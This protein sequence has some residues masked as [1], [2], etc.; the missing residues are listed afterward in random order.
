LNIYQKSLAKHLIPVDFEEN[1]IKLTGFVSAIEMTR[2]NRQYQIAFVNNRY[3]KSKTVEEAIATVY[4]TLIP[5][6]RFPIVFLNVTIDPSLIDI[7]IH[8]AKTEIRFHQEGLIK[9][10]IYKAVKFEI[11]KYNLVPSKPLNSKQLPNKEVLKSYYD[12]NQ[13]KDEVKEKKQD[14]IMPTQVIKEKVAEATDKKAFNFRQTYPDRPSKQETNNLLNSYKSLIQDKEPEVIK[15][16]V[17]KPMLRTPLTKVAEVVEEIYEAPKQLFED[18]QETIYDHLNFIGQMFQTYLIYEKNS[19]MYLIDQH[20]AHEKILYEKF[21]DDYKNKKM[22]SQM[23]LEPIVVNV[24]KMTLDN[25]IENSKLFLN[26]GFSIEAFGDDALLIREIP[27]GF[28]I[29]TSKLIFENLIEELDFKL[30]KERF[31]LALD[32]LASRSCKAAIKA[33][34]RLMDIEVS[35]LVNQLKGL[36]EPYTCPHGRPIIIKISKSEIEKKFNRT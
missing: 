32:E 6:N 29:K 17:S 23:I 13:T 35:G 7:N 11:N 1:G 8:P 21:L 3:V 22:M 9:D 15:E 28:N 20:A 16:S 30:P 31:E 24:N 27:L 25:A 4:R 5:H 19:Q 14:P 10:L 12:V 26:L 18:Q 36:N 34:D 33:N 2:G